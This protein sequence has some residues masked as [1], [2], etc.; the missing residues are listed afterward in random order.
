MLV[1]NNLKTKAET[2]KPGRQ[3][4][5]SL[6]GNKQ[7]KSI[8]TAAEETAKP[9]APRG[10]GRKSMPPG[11]A[12]AADNVKSTEPAKRGRK[13]LA[14]ITAAAAAVNADKKLAAIK[15]DTYSYEDS[16]ENVAKTSG[17]PADEAGKKTKRKSVTVAESNA[18]K[19]PVE[20]KF[21]FLFN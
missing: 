2:T 11:A 14:A 5:K 10:R 15:V 18:E 20:L 19:Q 21:K 17:G 13:S 7:S 16:D 3:P 8:E 1:I 12:A 9:T 6:A 4:R